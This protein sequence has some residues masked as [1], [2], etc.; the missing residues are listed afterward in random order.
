MK[1]VDSDG[2]LEVDETD[3][4]KVNPSEYDKVEDIVELIHLNMS[5]ALHVLRQ[6]YGSSLIH[7]FAGRHLIIINPRRHLSL[8]SDRVR[9]RE[10]ERERE[11]ER[12]GERE[13]EKERERENLFICCCRLL[14]CSEVVEERMYH[15]TY[16]LP[17]NKH[18]IT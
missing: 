3:I 4:E 10:R 8:Y 11:G 2:V 13:R 12:E 16:T 9:E 7:T 14:K 15:H 17:D 6:R 18:I 1:L 5:S